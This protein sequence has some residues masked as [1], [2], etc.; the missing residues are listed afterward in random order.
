M[1]REQCA[2]VDV[3]RQAVATQNVEQQQPVS[4]VRP[5]AVA[6]VVRHT[7]H[8]TADL[9]ALLDSCSRIHTERCKLLGAARSTQEQEQ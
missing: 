2:S 9:V 5:S 4:L 7:G 6:L 3:E 1:S 8:S